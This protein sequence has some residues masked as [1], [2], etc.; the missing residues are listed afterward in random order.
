FGIRILKSE[1][2]FMDYVPTSVNYW[3]VL[4]IAAVCILIALLAAVLPG[5]KAAYINPATELSGK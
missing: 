5:I 1:T 3:E 2:Y 4:A